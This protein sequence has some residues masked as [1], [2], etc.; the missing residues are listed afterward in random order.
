MEVYVVLN[1]MMFAREALGVFSSLEK[2]Q[3]YMDRFAEKTGYYC[4]IERSFVRGTISPR[5]MYLRRTPM[6]ALKMFMSWKGYI[7]NCRRRREQRA[8]RGK[9]LNSQLTPRRISRYL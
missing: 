8:E 3:K 6:T 9:Q 4:Q 2:A 1:K 7:R 5:I